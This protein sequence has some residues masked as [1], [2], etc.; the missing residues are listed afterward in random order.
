LRSHR[1]ANATDGRAYDQTFCRALYY[2]DF[3][4]IKRTN[5]CADRHTNGNPDGGANVFSNA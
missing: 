3:E 4:S 2:T 5:R 1:S